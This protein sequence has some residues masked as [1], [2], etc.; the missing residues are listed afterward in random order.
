M[1]RVDG[2]EAHFIRGK[3]KMTLRVGLA[4]TVMLAMALGHLK[5][6]RADHIRS[7]VRAYRPPDRKA[8]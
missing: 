6:Q 5:E 3:D 2:F 1:D 7:L 8:G 4:L